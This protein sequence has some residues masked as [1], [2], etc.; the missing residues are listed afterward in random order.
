VVA[1]VS[2][3]SLRK[4]LP[5]VL[6][7]A[8]PGGFDCL[9]MVKPQ[10]ELDRERVGKGGVVRSVEDRRAA[11]RAVADWALGAG[12]AV[13]GL[14]SSGLPGPSGNRETF[15]WIAAGGPVEDIEAAVAKVEP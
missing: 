1:D 3:I 14:A 15:V 11:L 8:A 5:A 12:Y 10:F 2:F 4:V 7:C 13:R 9:A 6:E